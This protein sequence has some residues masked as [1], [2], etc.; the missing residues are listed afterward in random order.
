MMQASMSWSRRFRPGIAPTLMVIAVIAT[1]V[2]LGRWQAGRAIEK[3]TAAATVAKAQAAA[4]IHVRDRS[5][6]LSEVEHRRVVARGEFIADSTIYLSNRTRRG[7]S[8]FE[9]LTALRTDGGIKVVVD[10]GWT[11][12]DPAHINN[13]PRV[14]TPVGVVTVEGMAVADPGRFAPMLGAAANMDLPA[15]AIWPNFAF[16]AYLRATRLAVQPFVVLQTSAL[17]DGLLREWTPPGTGAQKHW[18]YA[19]QWW[20]MAAAAAIWW[21]WFGITRARAATKG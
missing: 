14:M 10:R 21:V 20:A 6:T 1:T 12:A 17:D 19:V 3:E 16:D 15:G 4:P 2:S 8:G 11:A 9:V 13:A 7:V 18:S 5:L